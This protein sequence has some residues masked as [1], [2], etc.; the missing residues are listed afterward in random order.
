MENISPKIRTSFITVLCILTFIGSGWGIISGIMNYTSADSVG[1]TKDLIEDSLDDA[2]DQMDDNEDMTDGQKSFIE[3]M[4]GSV[5]GS[6]TPEKIRSSSVIS[7]LSC[8]ITIAGAVLMW[9]LNKKGFYIYIVGILVSIV[10]LATIF[11]GL[12]G[13]LA[14]GGTGFVGVIMI[15][16]YGVNLKDMNS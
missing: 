12:I 15:I 11:G 7:I 9:S 2:M 4:L 8:M 3:N 1:A 13:A 5:T 10:G 16:L 6:F 14:A